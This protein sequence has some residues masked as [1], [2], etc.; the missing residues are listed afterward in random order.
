MSTSIMITSFSNACS[1][2]MAGT[3]VPN[4]RLLFFQLGT[5]G[6]GGSAPATTTGAY[7]TFDGTPPSG[8]GAEVGFEIDGA[9]CLKSTTLKRHPAP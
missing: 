4:G 7:P 9:N 6:A 2:Q 8:N 3:G 5:T 1:H